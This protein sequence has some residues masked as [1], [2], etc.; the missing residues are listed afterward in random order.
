MKELRTD[1]DRNNKYTLELLKAKVTP[2]KVTKYINRIRDSRTAIKDIMNI[3]LLAQQE[4][5]LLRHILNVV[6]GKLED[7][8]LKYGWKLSNCLFRLNMVLAPNEKEALSKACSFKDEKGN[9]KSPKQVCNNINNFLEGIKIN[10][11]QQEDDKKQGD[12]FTYPQ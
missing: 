2:D 1:I 3:A 4:L 7:K 9:D 6:P 12:E 11:W 5:N 10:K 8:F